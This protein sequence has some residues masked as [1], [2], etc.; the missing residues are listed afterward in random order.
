MRILFGIILSVLLFACNNGDPKK[1]ASSKPATDT[2]MTVS[3]LVGHVKLAINPAYTDWVLFSNGTY[4]ILP[5]SLKSD[6]EKN[7]LKI[8]KEFGPVH[9]GGSAG[10]MTVTELNSTEGWSV[11]GHYN[12][13]Y[14]YV[15]PSELTR[16]GISNPSDLDVG[17]Y[18]RDKRN[19]DS[20]ELKVVHV[21]RK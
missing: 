15:H 21:N 12:G 13:M 11:G 4:I 6:T 14:T 17:L 16:K 7:A 8:L 20:R 2:L 10:D 5:D 9:A 1:A 18:G 19:S 3:E